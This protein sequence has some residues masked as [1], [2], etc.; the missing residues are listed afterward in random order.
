MPSMPSAIPAPV[1]QA[2]DYP[3]SR[4]VRSEEHTSEL[5]SR[6]YLVCC[7]LLDKNQIPANSTSRPP[8]ILSPPSIMILCNMPPST[9]NALTPSRM[10]GRLA[11]KC[12]LSLVFLRI[13]L[14][15]A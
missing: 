7:L 4:L 10:H 2:V 11:L 8:P 5:Q 12:F 15:S 1:F 9:Y 6:Q 14:C 13:R 3:T